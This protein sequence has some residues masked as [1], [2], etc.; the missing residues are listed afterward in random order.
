M[1]RSIFEV[2]PEF[3]GRKEFIDSVMAENGND[4]EKAKGE[5]SAKTLELEQVKQDLDKA[6]ESIASLNA[7]I[8]TFNGSKSD[9]EALK[10][11]L[12]E[13]EA[14]KTA[15][16]QA[17]KE[18]QIEL[19]YKSRF[20]AAIGDVEFINEFTK[21]GAYAEFKKALLDPSNNGVG[22]KDIFANISKN[23]QN[24]FKSKQTF[25][26]IQGVA[27]LDMSLVN[28]E[29]FKKMSLIQQMEFANSHPAEYDAISKMI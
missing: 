2:V 20:D 6:N 16:E 26:N 8:E 15:R 25:P 27:N 14:E 28:A 10:Q 17:E 29:T 21:D 7:T 19:G 24:W 11:K 3:E 5:L 9:V 13:F 4:I 22:D 1:N 18:R 23:Q 12:A